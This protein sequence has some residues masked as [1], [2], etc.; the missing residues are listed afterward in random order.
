MKSQENENVS[1]TTK[2]PFAIQYEEFTSDGRKYIDLAPMYDFNIMLMCESRSGI[3]LYGQKGCGKTTF[4]R[5]FVQQNLKDALGIDSVKVIYIFDEF[6]NGCNME[7][8]GKKL[9]NVCSTYSNQ[10]VILFFKAEDEATL[11]ST[12]KNFEKYANTIKKQCNNTLLKLVIEYTVEDEKEWDRINSIDVKGFWLCSVQI[13]YNYKKNVKVYELMARELSNIYNVKISKKVLQ[14]AIVIILGC[15]KKKNN[16]QDFYGYLETLFASARREKRNRISKSLIKKT[17]HELFEKI[18][19]RGEK[20]ILR[21]AYHE[22]GHALMG[23]ISSNYR[24]LDIVTVIPGMGYIGVT[25][26]SKAEESKK[27][28]YDRQAVIYEIAELA[29]GREAER[30]IIYPYTP[31]KGARNDLQCARELVDGL[32]FGDGI[33][34]AIGKN[35]VMK[36]DEP[37]SD[38]MRRHIELERKSIIEEATKIAMDEVFKH[39]DFIEKLATKVA[40]NLFVTGDEA[41]KMWVEH[42][43]EL[44]EKNNN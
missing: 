44:E 16:Y 27:F 8:V 33:S 14:M 38:I 5:R 12:T 19:E 40:E 4:M 3:I 37:I 20:E 29:A 25:R 22:S 15:I 11:L 7:E 41:R 2:N 17:F 35:V 32:I 13:P 31:N 43:K 9:V 24:T 42:L 26:F 39:K 30:L 36:N 6:L 18:E 34:T 10:A 23:L 28:I 1:T 21:I